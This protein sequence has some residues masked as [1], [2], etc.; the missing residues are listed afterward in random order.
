[1]TR[2]L[3]DVPSIPITQA[4]ELKRGEC[5]R[6]LKQRCPLCFGGTSFGR[7]LSQWVV[8][9]NISMHSLTCAD[10]G[11]DIHFCVDGNF[12][13][14]HGISAGESVPFHDPAYILSK[15]FV[16]RVGERVD[17]Q[18]KRTP[19]SYR[20]KVPDEAIDDCEHSHEAADGRKRKANTDIFDD[21]GLMALV[22]RHD[23]P[24]F[25][26]N[27]DTPGE[28]QKYAIALIEHIFSLLPPDATGTAFY[29]VGCVLERSLNKVRCILHRS[30]DV[31][32]SSLFWYRS[33]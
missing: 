5:A 25:F 15:S 1:M 20:P 22:C 14:R 3:M 29:D 13:H 6:I 9:S 12:H 28:Q 31:L 24:L 27:I 18:R 26:T 33:V 16:D 32:Q 4:Y 17:E 23:I 19:R 10:R 11:G 7:P 30:L 8:P 21:T 2:A